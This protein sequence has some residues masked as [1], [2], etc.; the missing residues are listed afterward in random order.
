[1]SSLG[2]GVSSS[3]A[4]AV[5]YSVP[6]VCLGRHSLPSFAWLDFIHAYFTCRGRGRV[7]LPAVLAIGAG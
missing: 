3:V 4:I 1:M 7:H 2:M 6:A 5:A